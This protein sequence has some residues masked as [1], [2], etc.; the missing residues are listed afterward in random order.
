L[1]LEID[2][3]FD[4]DIEQ[5]LFTRS[6]QWPFA[7]RNVPS[8]FFFTGLHPDYHSPSDRPIKINYGK[9]EKIAR[10]AY[11]AAWSLA[12]AEDRPKFSPIP[13]PADE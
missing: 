4:R 6:D 10:L 5:S 9:M 13:I 1:D 8:L 3:K 7:I 12:N 2:Y 11:R